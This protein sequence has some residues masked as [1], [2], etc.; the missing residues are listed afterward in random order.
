MEERRT[1]FW[2]VQFHEGHVVA[3]TSLFRDGG[4]MMVMIS[5]LLPIRLLCI[6]STM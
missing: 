6:M 3:S 4:E 2:V 5:F 1:P